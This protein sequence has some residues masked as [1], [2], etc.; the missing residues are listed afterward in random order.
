[1]KILYTIS[2][3]RTTQIKQSIVTVTKRAGTAPNSVLF[4]L[5]LLL[6]NLDFPVQICHCLLL[7][8]LGAFGVNVHCGGD[9][10]VAHDVLN[11]F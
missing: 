3:V 2:S 5:V 1:M 7:L 11:D 4:P 10:C 6:H 9:V 8:F